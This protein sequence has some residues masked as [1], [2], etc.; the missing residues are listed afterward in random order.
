MRCA[1]ALA[2]I[3]LR[4][5]VEICPEAQARIR[6]GLEQAISDA[7]LE[8]VDGAEAVVC[9][10]SDVAEWLRA[11]ADTVVYIDA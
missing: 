4:T 9:L 1:T 6:A 11:E 2:R 5:L 7:Q 10:L 3:A 8:A